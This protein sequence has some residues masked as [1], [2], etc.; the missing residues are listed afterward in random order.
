MRNRK[1]HRATGSPALCG[2]KLLC[3]FSQARAGRRKQEEKGV[4]RHLNSKVN[5]KKRKESIKKHASVLI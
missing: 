4:E 2:L 1:P 3:E 5:S